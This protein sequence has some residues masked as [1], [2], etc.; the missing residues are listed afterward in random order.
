MDENG[1]SENPT[2]KKSKRIDELKTH[3]G[4]NLI[5]LPC[6]QIE[7]TLSKNVLLKTIQELENNENLNFVSANEKDYQNQYLGSYTN[8]SISELKKNYAAQSGTISNKIQFCKNSDQAYL[9][10]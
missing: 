1:T 6:R 4:E 10:N 3:L 8:N 7:N 5:V 2:S 9:S